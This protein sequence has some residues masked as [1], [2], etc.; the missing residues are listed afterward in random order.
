[1]INEVIGMRRD[2]PEITLTTYVSTDEENVAP[3][4]AILVLPGGAYHGLAH[5]EG[6]KIALNY[7]AHGINAFVLK[8]SVRSNA[9][10]M[11]YPMPIVDASNAMKYIKDNAKKYNV[12]P[13]KIFVIGFSAGA[14]LASMLGTIWHRDE[15]YAASEPMEY[16]YNKPAGMILSY[17]V[18]SNKNHAGSLHNLIC[19]NAEGVAPT[20]EEL[21]SLASDLNVDER[22]VPAFMWHTADDGCVCVDG[23]L[24]M[25]KALSANKIPF[26]LHVYPHGRHGLGIPDGNGTNDRMKD[27]STWLKHS[28]D[29]IMS[30]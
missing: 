12:D 26:E 15:V 23:T 27:V 19:G 30:F 24:N 8:Y 17:P 1:M 6:E 20:E 21:I 4:S 18:I 29:W 16:G 25:A 2:N 9:P 22:T 28:V 3:R 14:H 10:D 13:D 7:L 5:H 11:H